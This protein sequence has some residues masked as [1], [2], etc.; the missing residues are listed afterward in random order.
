MSWDETRCMNHW[1]DYLNE[2]CERDSR[3]TVG[4]SSMDK[5]FRTSWMLNEYNNY[6][7]KCF[8]LLWPISLPH[9]VSCVRFCLA[10]SV[11]FLFVYEISRESQNGFATN[12]HGRRVWSLAGTCLKFKVK[13]QRS[14]SMSPGTKNNGI[15]RPN[16]AACVRFTFGKTFSA[17]V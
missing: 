15:L 17:S 11:T 1:C 5:E 9:A 3:K 13:G 10:L 4:C 12:S 7:I 16:L 8:V 14:R 6:L 2:R